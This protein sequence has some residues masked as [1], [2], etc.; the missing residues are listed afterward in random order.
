VKW[1]AATAVTHVNVKALSASL[2]HRNHELEHAGTVLCRNPMEGAPTL[3][4]RLQ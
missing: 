4:A 1:R 3:I 2:E